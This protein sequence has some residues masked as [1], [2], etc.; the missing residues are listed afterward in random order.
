MTK[1]PKPPFSLRHP[2]VL[3]VL[4]FVLLFLTGLT[5]YVAFSGGTVGAADTRIVSVKVDGEEQVVPTRADSV[6]EL[7][8]RLQITLNPGDKVEPSADTPIIEDN[9]Q[10]NVYRARPVAVV[11]AGTR[12][13]I[14]SP[15]LS[16]REVATAAGL[17]LYPEDSASF[18]QS[19][20][21]LSEGIVA[22]EVTI[23]R[24]VPL[25][26]NIYGALASYRTLS[27][28]LQDF[29]SEKGI[30][31]GVGDTTQPVEKSTAIEANM[32]VS[33]NSPGKQT[34]AIA[35]PINFKVESVNDSSVPAGQTKV[36]QAGVAGQ[37]AI[38]YE[39]SFENGV[40]TS[41]RILQTVVTREPQNEVRARG[42]QA[43]SSYSV[44]EDRAS[45]MRAAGIDP[46]QFDAVDF[47]IR[48][49]STWRPAAVNANGCIGLGQRCPSRGTNALAQAC[50]NWQT[51]PVCQL[52]H[53]TAYAN[54]RYGSWNEARAAWES[55][56]WW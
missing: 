35:E 25:T 9:Q 4:A 53:F 15:E 45:L 41:R 34:L 52:G 28:T 43:V 5:A 20:E 30:V 12:K 1:K 21:L 16:A 31:L 40:E 7:L 33:I 2:F 46:S 48:K 14:I 47:I 50:P 39:L 26:A 32:L 42:T 8:E 27:K 38:I 29:L 23:E 56:R 44:S 55:Q 19:E 22:E 6:G 24:S 54:G 51:D 17:S 13:I 18:R 10:I 11:E 3:P 49:E 37:K 36:T